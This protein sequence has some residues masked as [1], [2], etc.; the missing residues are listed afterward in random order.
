MLIINTSLDLHLSSGATIL[1]SQDPD[2]YL[3]VVFTRWQG[4]ELMNYSP[5][6]YCYGQH[7]VAVTGQAR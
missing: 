1:F 5:F 2:D 4:I 7:N 3:P 6:V